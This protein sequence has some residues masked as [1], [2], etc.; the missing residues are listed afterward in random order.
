MAT[1]FYPAKP[2]FMLFST[3]LYILL[4]SITCKKGNTAG[5]ADFETNPVQY[6]VAAGS[7]DEASGI[8]D[9]KTNPGY[10]WVQQ[11]S[12]NPTDLTLL[13]HKGI[14]KKKI[15]L[16]G[17]RNRDWEDMAVS[18][19]PLAGKSYIYIAD[20]G[21]NGLTY[22]QY[23]I[24]RFEEPAMS[25]DTVKAWDKLTF[26]YPDGPH[27][28]EAILVDPD[29]KDIF[30]ITKRETQSNIYRFAYPQNTSAVNTVE[31]MGKLAYNSVVSAALPPDG[32]SVVIKTYLGIF[33]Y[34]RT[35]GETIDKALQKSYK[36]LPYLMEQQ[37]EAICFKNDN[38]GYFT[39][40]E[41]RVSDVTLNFYKRK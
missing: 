21:D 20:V 34:E 37:G 27:D 38:S 13:G 4:F 23:F 16:E 9:S 22:G 28:A 35:K 17:T 2:R 25:V 6:P 3:L 5:Q 19:G 14:V 33:Q 40:S 24:Y 8:A 15:Y 10:L 11:D 7:V 36:T 1:L 32:K 18:N 41:R 39:L 29:T 26:T 30:I 12:D 31:F